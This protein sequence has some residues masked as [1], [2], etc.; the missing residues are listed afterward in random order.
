MG[1]VLSATF[2]V[3]GS[4]GCIGSWVV[5][6]LVEQ[7]E[8]CVA[9][10]LVATQRRL[11]QIAD[12]SVVEKVTVVTGDINEDGLIASIASDHHVSHVIHLAALLAPFVRANPIL[13]AQVS[14]VGTIR[15]FEAVRQLKDQVQGFA[16]ASSTAVFGP[17][18]TDGRPR[19]LYGVF[20]RCNEETARLYAQDWSVASVG[21]RPTALFGVG[22]DQG[23][24]AAPTTAIK[25][26]ALKVP[27]RIPFGGSL[28]LQYNADVARAFIAAA[29][30]K[31]AGA[32]VYNVRGSI[33]SVEEVANTIGALRPIAA[34]IL[35]H[36]TEP[37]P[38]AAELPGAYLDELVTGLPIT[39][40]RTAVIETLER[41]ERLAANGELT[42]A[43]LGV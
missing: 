27:Y 24:D 34:D 32:R 10:D 35:T 37:L 29:R 42:K 40:F 14:V 19:G 8:R 5:K 43:E 3:T 26:V 1:R 4:E 7:G 20:K 11:R 30:A 16:Y 13:G 25:A 17:R 9:L 41:Y 2:L 36:A 18:E 31:V 12:P 21:L 33:V 15:V 38:Q 23:V 28:H 6:E 22:R 39:P